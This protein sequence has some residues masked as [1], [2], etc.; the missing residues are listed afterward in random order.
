MSKNS[1]SEIKL[2]NDVTIYTE[3]YGDKTNKPILL[4][5][6]AGNSRLNWSEDFCKKLSNEGFYVIRMDSRDAGLSK[7][8]PFGNPGYGLMDLVHDVIGVLD[9]FEIQK[10]NVVGVSQGAALTQLLAIHYPERVASICLISSTPGGPG[11]DANDLPS[12]T[13]EI[14]AIFNDPNPSQPDWK[15]KEE[16]VNYLIEAERP[17]GGSIF[18]EEFTR[19]IAS[20]TY[21]QMS[22]L[23]AT[24]V[25][26][27]FMIDAGDPWRDKLAKIT[28]PT[29]VV[30]GSEDPFFPVEHGKALAQEIPNARLL[31]VDGMGH[32]NISKSV[33][34][35]LIENIKKLVEGQPNG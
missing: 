11:H 23:V 14:T 31:I 32:A 5:H 29:L 7:K 20:D 2:E 28:V 34:D 8:F 17:F 26:N 6:G 19:R 9:H 30:H 35:L 21:D 16:V 25:T 27:P 13:E 4:L 15:N 24:Q 33:W 1:A 12:A 22:E 18:D 10:I 3:S